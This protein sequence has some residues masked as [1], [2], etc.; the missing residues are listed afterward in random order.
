M[1]SPEHFRAETVKKLKAAFGQPE[2]SKVASGEIYR[3]TLK[4][5]VN[6]IS[7]F[8]TL[9]SPEFT[10]M[11]HIMISDGSAYQIEPVV[12]VTVRTQA[13][14]DALIERIFKQ[15]RRDSKD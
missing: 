5:G 6:E 15:L 13:E 7:M 10:D 4:R 11:A 3:W 12:A 9:D 1:N 8:I 14:V 2:V